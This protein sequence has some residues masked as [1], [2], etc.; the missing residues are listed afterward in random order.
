MVANLPYYIA[1]NIILK[2]LKDKNCQ[3]ILVMVQKE[4]AQKFS[5]QSGEKAFSSLSVLTQ[6]VGF[7]KILFDVGAENFIPPPKVTSSIL[8]IQK[9]RSENNK[10]FE[11]FLK[12]AFKQPRKKLSKNLATYYDKDKVEALLNLLELSPTIRPHEAETAM[13]HQLY[14]ELN[15]DN[16]D[17]RTK[18]Q[19]RKRKQSK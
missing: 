11:E 1:T 16:I 3:S 10:D 6:S 12:V 4:V 15:K 14:N 13:Y 5:A 2:A 7:G 8:L 17:G 9:K 19:P 18:Q